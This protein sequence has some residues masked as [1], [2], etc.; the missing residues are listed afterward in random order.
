M[1]LDTSTKTGFAVLS[2]APEEGISLIR[3]GIISSKKVGFERWAAMAEELQAILVLHRPAF[4]VTEGYGFGN[5]N[6]LATLV[7]V[8][9]VLR[10]FIWQEGLTNILI[11]PTTLKKFTTGRGNSKKEGM[12]LEVYKRW[13]HEV[14]TNDEADAVALGY[15]GLAL[16]G[17]DV[18]LP[19][20]NLSAVNRYQAEV[21]RK[22]LQSSAN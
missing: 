13:G 6:T 5:A 21:P 20:V 3:T 2:F 19:K 14:P 18:A 11:P 1:G 7:E 4:L 15:V 12:L 8:G 17:V 10:Y 22:F 9:T 16:S